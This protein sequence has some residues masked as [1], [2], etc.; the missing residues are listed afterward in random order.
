MFV[1]CQNVFGSR[2][3]NFD[4]CKFGIILMH[5]KPIAYTVL[6]MLILGQ[7]LPTKA[8]N[9]GPPRTMMIPQ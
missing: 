3:C 4:G 5:I 6:K 7:G 1:G 2:G 8:A 9:I